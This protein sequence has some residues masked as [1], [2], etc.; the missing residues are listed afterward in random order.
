[1]NMMKSI[2]TKMML[3]LSLLMPATF[4][5]A[6]KIGDL[7][8]IEGVRNNQLQGIG[9]VVGLPNTGDRNRFAT[10]NMSTLIQKY[11]IK[12]PDNVSLRSRNVAAVMV[13]A[14]LPP[15]AK[16]GQPIDVTVSSLADA[17]SLR[18]G[19]L[20]ATPLMGLNGE[21]FGI[22]QGQV[23]VDGISATGLDGSTIDVNS[24]SVG[25]IPSGATVENEL[26]YSA[27][28]S[29]DHV[30]L[31][32]NSS[33]FATVNI[34]EKAINETFGEGVAYARDAGMLNIIAPRDESSRIEFIT[35]I[36]SIS[37]E[38]PEPEARV[39][40]NSRTGTV[41]FT[42]NVTLS[43]VAISQGSI[44]VNVSESQD[45]SQGAPLGGGTV[46]TQNSQIKVE[47]SQSDLEVI[48]SAGTLQ[49]LVSAMNAVGASGKDMVSIIQLLRQSGSLRA[50][51]I[52][53]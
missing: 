40:V 50:N 30:N 38:L 22:A 35:L 49:D 16:K 28:F 52:V 24:S 13:N 33:D 41:M 2:S 48:E 17:K 37:V 32:L 9:L 8:S 18:G 34:I 6:E 42:Q 3:G 39:V 43:P 36:N 46:V 11:G 26:D 5:N 45:V 7:T 1:M 25:R 51:V 10:E 4:A 44:I 31:N 14:T 47:S 15:F 12:V 53:I 27:V 23:L 29:G 21:V 20:I 19:T